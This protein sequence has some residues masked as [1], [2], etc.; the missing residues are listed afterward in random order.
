LDRGK[1]GRGSEKMKCDYLKRKMVVKGWNIG[2]S[3][4]WQPVGDMA[5]GECRR[6]VF[7]N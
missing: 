2:L 1:S 4:K 6:E 7:V 3:V 5:E